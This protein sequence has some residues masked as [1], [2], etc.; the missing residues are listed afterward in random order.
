MPKF[1]ANLSFLWKDLDPPARIHA[2]AAVGFDA[3]EILFPYDTPA[4]DMRR[5]LDATGL[6]LALINC[7]PP[8][9]TGGATIGRRARRLGRPAGATL[10]SSLSRAPRCTILQRRRP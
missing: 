8:N 3:V 5:A 7:P 9:Y 10:M 1:C 4:Q 6:V 2:A